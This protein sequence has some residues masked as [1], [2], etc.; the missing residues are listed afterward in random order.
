MDFVGYAQNFWVESQAYGKESWSDIIALWE[1]FNRHL[2][3]VIKQAPA[4]KLGNTISIEG[5]EY[6]TLAFIMDDY[7]EHL[8][9]HLKQILPS[10]GFVSSF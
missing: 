1:C 4:E 7:V 5:S 10:G 6:S 9:H 2:A 3:H 8:K